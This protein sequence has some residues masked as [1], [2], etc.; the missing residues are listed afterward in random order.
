METIMMNAEQRRAFV[1]DHRTCIFGFQRK[2]GPPS[3]SVVYYTTEGDDVLIATMAARAKAKAVQRVGEASICVLDEKWPLTYLQLYGPARLDTD[4]DLVVD[5]M[6]K[7]GEIMSGQPLPEEAR[8]F[9]EEIARREDRV[10]I[11]LSPEWTV[12]SPPVHLNAG[13]DG[14]KMQHGLGQR[15]PWRV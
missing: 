3:M 15:L 6:V 9:V 11:R 14:S 13:D 2:E 5:T 7:V 8:P 1:R 4:F 12:Y 10:V